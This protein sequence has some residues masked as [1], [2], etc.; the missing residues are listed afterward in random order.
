M[1]TI[2]TVTVFDMLNG[3]KESQMPAA[4]DAHFKKF[5]EDVY[6]VNKNEILSHQFKIKNAQLSESSGNG[7][8]AVDPKDPME[9]IAHALS[10]AESVLNTQNLVI[11]NALVE[12][13]MTID[14]GS[15]AGTQTNVKFGIEPQSSH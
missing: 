7:E 14:A 1:A 8:T 10:N 6:R 5:Y 2:V 4:L 15:G 12:M 11:T 9:K 3:L 13:N